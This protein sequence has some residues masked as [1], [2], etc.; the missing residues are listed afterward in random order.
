MPPH[1]GDQ[2]MDSVVV[3]KGSGSASTA[4]PRCPP[5]QPVGSSAAAQRSLCSPAQF[6]S[7]CAY[8]RPVGWSMG[9]AQT[10]TGWRKLWWRVWSCQQT[11]CYAGVWQQSL[12]EIWA[13]AQ[14]CWQ[15][16]SQGLR[17][18][19]DSTGRAQARGPLRWKTRPQL[20][21]TK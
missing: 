13:A 10:G 17:V 9:I 5:A 19:E 20:E 14:T 7:R 11:C 1:P 3:C 18:C 8:H 6:C 15:T 12:G 16:R 4:L 2:R 21:G